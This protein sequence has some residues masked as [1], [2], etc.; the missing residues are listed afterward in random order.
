MPG[1]TNMGLYDATV[2]AW[3]TTSA[4]TNSFVL[5][6]M[7]RLQSSPDGDDRNR[8]RYSRRLLMAWLHPPRPAEVPG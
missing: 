2:R 4:S 5:R 7:L 6:T 1:K 3:T 8:E